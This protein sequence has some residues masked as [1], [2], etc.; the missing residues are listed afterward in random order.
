M[1][2]VVLALVAA[3]SFSSPLIAQQ[4]SAWADKLFGG[5]TTYDFGTVARGAQLKHTFKLTNIY[6]VPL[7]ITDVRVTCGCVKPELSVKTLQPNETAMLDILMDARQFIGSKTVRV[8]VTVG[9]KY[10]STATLTVS[11]NARGD[12]AFSPTEID[13]GNLH[14]GQT[15]TKSLD[16]EYGGS[17][18]DWRVTEIVKSGAAPFELKVQ[19]LPRVADG[20]PRKGYRILAT[21]KAD[22]SAGSFKQEIVL[23]TNDPGAAVLTF[24]IT[25]NVQAGLAVSPSPIH[26]MDLKVGESQTKKVFVRAARPFRVV[27]VDGQ[28]EGITVDIPNREDST[29]VLTVNIAPTKAGDLR[30][31]L[32]IRT[33]LDGDAVPLV[34]EGKIEP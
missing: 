28:G 18:I 2:K 11:A 22:S 26:I 16:V 32:M 20:P 10:I 4:P 23:K 30:R 7:D 14:R 19:E 5:E 29:L 21:I 12:V 3:F 13:F 15:P 33:D 27:A 25:G 31:Q 17:Q 34:I 9:P 1:G 8:L 24:N 6:K